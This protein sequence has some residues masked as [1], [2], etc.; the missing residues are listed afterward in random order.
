MLMYTSCGWF[1]NELSGIETVQVMQYAGRA[2]QL[3][4]DVLGA[5]L[6]PGLLLRLEEARSNIPERDHGRRIYQTSVKPAMVDLPKVAAHYAI[7]S[8]FEPYGEEEHIY[9]YTVRQLDRRVYEAGRARLVLGRA[10]VQSDITLKKA[11]L[12]FGV[13]HFGDHNVN[14]GVR[15]FRGEEAYEDLLREVTAPFD[16]ADFPAVLRLLDR[17]FGASTYSLGSLFWDE[18]RRIL[19][20]ML[21]ASLADAEEEYRRIYQSQAAL[22]RFVAGLNIPQPRAFRMAAE[23]VLNTSLRRAFEQDRPSLTRIQTLLEEARTGNITLDEPGLSYALETTLERTAR[24]W[25][26][27]PESLPELQRLEGIAALAYSLPFNVSLWEVQ[28]A[29]WSVRQQ[30]YDSVAR[31]ARDGDDKAVEWLERFRTL[32]KAVAV[33]VD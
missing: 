16:R 30:D 27:H 31:R 7:S 14:A 22:T 8:L 5:D 19:D 20:I 24:R 12:T 6:E 29:V 32:A 9:C 18:Q 25:R 21:Q 28:N 17:H 11:D 15:E 26:A 33:A 3:A 13:L 10:V 23:F 2:V 1:F 4:R